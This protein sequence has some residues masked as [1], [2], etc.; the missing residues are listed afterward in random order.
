MP[1]GVSWFS[2][3]PGFESLEHWLQGVMGA[4]FYQKVPIHA[5]HVVA[6][7]FVFLCVIFFASIARAALA[8]RGDSVLPDEKLTARNFFE[9]FL[10]AAYTL[11]KDII[12]PQAHRYFPLIGALAVFIFFSNMLGQIPGLLPPTQNL[13]TTAACALTVFLSYHWIGARGQGFFK[14]FGHMANPMGAWWGWLLAP[15]M[16]PIEMISHLARPMSLSLR[17]MGNMT[18]DHVLLGI[19][20]GLVPCVVPIPFQ[21][22]GLLV[23]VVQTLVFCL[24]STVYI[25]LALAHEEEGHG[26]EH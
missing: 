4:S 3:L 22:L 13:N 2:F 9:I 16:F 1:H 19:F 18:G 24:L 12:G 23:A 25:S 7:L 15:L 14:Y 26:H 10:E 6:A 17:L 20:L 11:M 21:I 5:Q 8:R